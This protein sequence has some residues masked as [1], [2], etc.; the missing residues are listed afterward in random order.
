MAYTDLGKFSL[1]N[2]VQEGQYTVLYFKNE[3]DKD[4]YELCSEVPTTDVTFLAIADDGAV[5]GVSSDLSTFN[6][7]GFRFLQSDDASEASYE[8]DGHPLK[9]WVWDG[10]TMT[11]PTGQEDAILAYD[12]RL[13]RDKIL[14][15]QVDPLVCNSL[16][17]DALTDAK[18]TE[19]ETYRQDLL[20]ISQQSGFPQ[21]I[22]WP[23]KPS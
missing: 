16:R 11:K 9:Q 1:Y 19:W 3:N 21:T 8:P 5:C 12:A 18:R 2:S 14:G 13:K 22:V 4:F 15:T 20:D 10:S 23:T 7:N 6:P 17:W